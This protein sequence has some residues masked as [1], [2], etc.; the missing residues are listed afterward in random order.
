MTES[1]FVPVEGDQ[2]KKF[3]CSFNV[4]KRENLRFVEI[5]VKCIAA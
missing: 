3:G 4:L 5:S 1:G 2:L